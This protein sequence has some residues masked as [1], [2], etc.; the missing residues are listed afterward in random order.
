ME[1][2]EYYLYRER[3][4]SDEIEILNGCGYFIQNPRITDVLI[5][6]SMYD[7]YQYVSDNN[8]VCNI[9]WDNFQKYNNI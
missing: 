6:R 5:F 8:I 4:N 7:I 9:C 3:P 2:K 1:R